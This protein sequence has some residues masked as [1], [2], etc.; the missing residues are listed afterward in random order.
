[1]T[2]HPLAVAGSG[3]SAGEH[4]TVLANVPPSV[5]SRQTVAS[6]DGSFLVE[7]A[8]VAGTPRGLRVRA[9]G[10]HGNAALYAPRPQ[11]AN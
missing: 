6:N 5:L 7:F 9:M 1:V 3:F 11:R 4:V 2:L 8:E 10:S